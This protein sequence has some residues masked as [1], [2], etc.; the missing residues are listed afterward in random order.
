MD[1]TLKTSKI[2]K[3]CIEQW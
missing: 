3:T 2:S 1:Q